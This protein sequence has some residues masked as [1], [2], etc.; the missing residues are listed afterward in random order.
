MGF[1]SNL[2]SGI[3][4]IGKSVAS[5]VSN[6]GKSVGSA[7]QNLG[8]GALG[9]GRVVS[10]VLDTAVDTV[11]TVAGEA[12]KIPVVGALLQGAMDTP[13]GKQIQNAFKTVEDINEALKQAISIGNRI[14]KFVD[15]VSGLSAEDLKNPSVRLRMGNEISNIHRDIQNSKV[16]QKVSQIPAFKRQVD[17]FNSVSNRVQNK[18]G[19]ETVEKIK[20]DIRQ[21]VLVQPPEI[22]L[23]F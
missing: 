21:R 18:L 2:A 7:V 13:I 6:V 11:K 1:F 8:K 12:V 4:N 9:V 3:S 20:K 17:K 14:E 16:G 19:K 10:G 22:P 5:T 23:R 15:D